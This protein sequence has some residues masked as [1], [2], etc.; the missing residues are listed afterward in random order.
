MTSTIG[1]I[2]AHPDD[3]TFGSACYIR[4]LADQG[5][6]PVLLLA[7]KGDAGKT[8]FLGPM[9]KEQLAE[10]RVQEMEKAAAILGIDVVEHLGHP[11]GKLAEVDVN[12]LSE[13]IAEFTNR[14]RCETIVSFPEDGINGHPDH[15][16]IHQA[17]IQAVRS[18]AC[19][20]VQRMYCLGPLDQREALEKAAIRVDTVPLWEMKAAALLAHESQRLAV[21]RVFGSLEKAPEHFRYETFILA[22]KRKQ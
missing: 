18:G 2:Y 1:F 16:A 5:H 3:E 11:D 17:A 7:T 14:Y 19:H 20:T 10:T 4:E 13:Q 22:W 6:R 8:G 9:S 21:N 15:V 12:Q